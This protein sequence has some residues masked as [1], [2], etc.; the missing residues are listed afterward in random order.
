MAEQI[1]RKI[2]EGAG[3]EA[4]IKSLRRAEINFEVFAFFEMA[5]LSNCQSAFI[6]LVYSVDDAPWNIFNQTKV[7]RF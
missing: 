3:K 2:I 1:W 5:F 7:F 6:P 4:Q